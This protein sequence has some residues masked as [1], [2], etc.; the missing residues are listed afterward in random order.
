MKAMEL[1]FAIAVTAHL[2]LVGDYNAVH[3]HVRLSRDNFIAGAYR[4]SE[5]RVSVY[6]GLRG[7]REG[8]FIEGGVVTGYTGADVAPYARVGYDFEHVTVFATPA[9]EYAPEPRV[10]MTLGLEWRF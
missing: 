3:P 8:W 2:G 4:N 6:A 10:G 1:S 5:S 7:E 9:Y